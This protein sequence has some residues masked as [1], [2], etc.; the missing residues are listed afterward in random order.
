MII[1][2]GIGLLILLG[3]ILTL[4]SFIIDDDSV[5]QGFVSKKQWWEIKRS[6]YNLGLFLSSVLAFVLYLIVNE[7]F[8][9]PDYEFTILSIII[10]VIFY[11]LMMLVANVFYGLGFQVD[12]IFNKRD[13][14]SYREKLFNLGFWV[15][16]S[17]PLLI[18]VLS[19][20]RYFSN[21]YQ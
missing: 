8:V 9:C 2:I 18:P 3:F 11:L 20:V 1:L 19:L 17:L 14:Q 4:K 10:S 16:L 13:S 5:K 15:S 12:K 7:I 21:C 6:K